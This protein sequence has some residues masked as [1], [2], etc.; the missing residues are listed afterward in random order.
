MDSL[1]QAVLGASV[2]AVAVPAPQRRIA[3][4]AGAALGTL[5]DL[6]VL[7][8]FGGPVRDFT[9]HRGFSHSLFV[10]V[11]FGL[12]LWLVLRA[13]WAPV[14]EAPRAWLAAILLVLVTHALLDAHTAYGTQ[15]LWPLGSPPV[16]W[17]TVFIIDPL[18]TVPLLLAVVLVLIKPR[19]GQA[20]HWLAGAL[21]LST[22]YLGWSWIAKAQVEHE[23]RMALADMGLADAPMFTT[24]TPFN[25]LLWRI[26]VMTDRGFLEGVDSLAVDDGPVRFAAF[27]SA[28]DAQRAAGDL[29]A[30]RRLAWFSRG[31]LKA[32][33]EQDRLILS[34]LR[35]GQEPFY[36]FSFAV[37]ERGNP[38]WQAIEPR[39]LGAEPDPSLLGGIWGRIWGRE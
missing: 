20:R 31:F 1:T 4:L 30:V 5:P 25:T 7:I 6:D 34:D 14:R 21:L 32:S 33:V 38:H 8:D 13:W 23:A 16:S 18:Y 10:L 29:W 39:Q 27:P 17:S 22:A 35:M 37:A 9:F 36:V 24:P 12:L 2:A 26:V 15:L 19:A 11:P 3:L 28:V